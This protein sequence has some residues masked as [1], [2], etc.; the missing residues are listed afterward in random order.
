VG[1]ELGR[2]GLKPTDGF[3]G[4]QDGEY[5]RLRG[6]MAAVDAAV[7]DLRRQVAELEARLTALQVRPPSPRP[8]NH[9]PPPPHPPVARTPHP[10]PPAPSVSFCHFNGPLPPCAPSPLS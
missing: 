4:S 9:P 7:G 10:S 6:R 1:G 8:F 2:G 5:L 3:A